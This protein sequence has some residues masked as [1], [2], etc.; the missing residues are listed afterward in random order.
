MK[1][2]FDMSRWVDLHFFDFASLFITKAT[3]LYLPLQTCPLHTK[4][5]F[6]QEYQPAKYIISS[7]FIVTE[8][9]FNMASNVWNMTFNLKTGEKLPT[10]YGID[11]HGKGITC[12][13]VS[14]EYDVFTTDMANHY[15]V[16]IR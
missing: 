6:L 15:Y 16:V 11:E 12:R 3:N 13:I 5:F 2:L 9:S 14:T 8:R 1:L 10:L 4:L 7:N